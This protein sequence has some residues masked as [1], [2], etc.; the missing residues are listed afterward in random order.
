MRIFQKLVIHTTQQTSA[1]EFLIEHFI[2]GKKSIDVNYRNAEGDTYLHEA[3]KSC[4]VDH[5][6]LTIVDLLIAKDAQLGIKN[7]QGETP[8]D[9]IFK[10]IQNP[11]EY[12]REKVFDPLIKVA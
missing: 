4:K 3:L 2:Q 8:I 5:A 11:V 7:S 10:Y 1:A 9:L 12:L 6:A